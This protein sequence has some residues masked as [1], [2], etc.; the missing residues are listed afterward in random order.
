MTASKLKLPAPPPRSSAASPRA[1]K[2]AA[3]TNKA[4]PSTPRAISAAGPARFPR[5]QSTRSRS[6]SRS[7]S[8]AIASAVQS[9][10]KKLPAHPRAVPPQPAR[11]T[12]P[13]S[14]RPAPRSNPQSCD[15][16]EASRAKL[17]RVLDVP[18][19]GNQRAPKAFRAPAPAVAIKLEE[20]DPPTAAASRCAA[21]RSNLFSAAPETR[22]HQTRPD[23]ENPAAAAL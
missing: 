11:D 6:K 13:F 8:P 12:P 22:V 21:S 23:P 19:R 10:A 3:H 1:G 9:K 5:K 4:P 7:R 18:R 16:P 14:E 15:R 2:A 17:R 20:A